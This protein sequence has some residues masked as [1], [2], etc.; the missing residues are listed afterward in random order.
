[1]TR[2]VCEVSQRSSECNTLDSS[3]ASARLLSCAS[4][5]QVG[6]WE[7]V[8]LP[9]RVCMLKQGVVLF[10]SLFLRVRELRRH[11]FRRFPHQGLE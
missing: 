1:M 9:I 2:L 6:D 5:E 8:G 3:T 4:D 11:L 10:N 7:V